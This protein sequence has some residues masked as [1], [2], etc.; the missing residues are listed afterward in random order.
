MKLRRTLP[1]IVLLAGSLACS[2]SAFAVI[3]GH[4]G[5]TRTLEGAFKIAQRERAGSVDGCYPAPPTLAATLRLGGKFKTAV[6]AGL[7]A[8]TR[9]GVVYV[10]KKGARC[11]RL[12]MALRAKGQLWI[13]NSA[14]GTVHVAGRSNERADY[15]RGSSGPLRSIT[16]VTK[17]LQLTRADETQRGEVLCPAG[18]YPLGGGMTGAPAPDSTG[19]GVYPHSFERL[20]VQR[21]W[22]VNPVL[23]DP[24]VLTNPAPTDTVPR[25]ATLQVVCGKGLVPASAPHKTV[26]MRSGETKTAIARC[27]KGQ[28]LISGGFQR[29]NFKTPGGNFVTESRAIGP[30][31]W[32]V[33][34]RA[35]GAYG[36]ELSSIAYCDRS[37]RPLLTTV[38]A[39]VPL[40]AG[41]LATATTPA[42]PK[43]Q[44]LTSGGFTA[45]GSQDTF[46]A[47]GAINANNSWTASSFGYFG[48]APSL[49]AFGYCLRPGI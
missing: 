4:N 36:G 48:P 35:F 42:C 1:L 28:V 19:E 37:K 47:S 26:F 8:V 49:T 13:L 3:A 5:P 41:Q 21:G 25:R 14:E 31:A 6:A 17:V 33:S 16:L 11:D 10:I 20:G 15:A 38:T 40:P 46:F 43:G 2:A 7:K 27:P 12:V 9:P 29:T 30:N 44:R 23:I 39:S 24:T 34:G 45:N 22:H 18:S 32:R